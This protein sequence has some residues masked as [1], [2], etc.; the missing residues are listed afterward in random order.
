MGLLGVLRLYAPLPIYFVGDL[1][2]MTER[3]ASACKLERV[4]AGV[5]ELDPESDRLA[6]VGL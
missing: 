2:S 3:W 5:A 4:Q 1:L 6:L